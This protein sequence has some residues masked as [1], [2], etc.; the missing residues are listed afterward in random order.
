MIAP[1]KRPQP[2]RNVEGEAWSILGWCCSKNHDS[3]GRLIDFCHSALNGR[4]PVQ[5][6]RAPAFTSSCSWR[7]GVA[8]RR[9]EVLESIELS[10]A[11]SSPHLVAT[12]GVP[13]PL[14][15][16]RES[17]RSPALFP[18]TF[19]R[20]NFNAFYQLGS[21]QPFRMLQGEVQPLTPRLQV[22]V[23]KGRLVGAYSCGRSNRFDRASVILS[24]INQERPI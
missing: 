11:C 17:G 14:H 20:R 13:L 3:V 9:Q 24:A 22:G 21:L 1:N 4:A 7:R 12:Y 6:I 16:V 23:A 8:P 15:M 10:R 19:E 2:R 5:F 18:A